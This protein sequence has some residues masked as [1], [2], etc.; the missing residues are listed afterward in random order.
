MTTDTLIQM[1]T[2]GFG[3]GKAGIYERVTVEHYDDSPRMHIRHERSAGGETWTKLT[4]W[5]LGPDGIHK[6]GDLA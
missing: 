4:E 5:E 1:Q 3:V 6:Q 2:G